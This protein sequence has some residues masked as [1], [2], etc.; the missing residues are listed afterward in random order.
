MPDAQATLN[1][2][3]VLSKRDLL[4]F[5]AF[6]TNE[7]AD[8]VGCARK[9][10]EK[11]K[12]AMKDGLKSALGDEPC[13]SLLGAMLLRTQWADNVGV[14]HERCLVIRH[15]GSRDSRIPTRP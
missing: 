10:I 15:R 3:Q 8:H 14:L 9:A 1:W 7:A 6:V 2:Q 4:L 12:A 13:I 11:F 5:E